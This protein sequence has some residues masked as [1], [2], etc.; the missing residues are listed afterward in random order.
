MVEKL[1]VHFSLPL[2]LSAITLISDDVGLM[3]C[4]EAHI[5]TLWYCPQNKNSLF[6]LVI[7]SLHP[8]LNAG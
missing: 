7:Y 3:V 1:L 4:N 8:E 5:N 6:P 2:N